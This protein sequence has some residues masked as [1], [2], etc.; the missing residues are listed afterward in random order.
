MKYQNP[1]IESSYREHDIGK[2]LYDLVLKLEPKKIVEIG[3]LHGYSTVAMAMALDEI[4][5]GHLHVYDL[6]EDYQY[7]HGTMD[8]VQ[9]N[10][11]KYGVSEYVTLTKK[12]FNEWIQ[13]PEDFDLLHVDISNNGDVIELLYEAVKDQVEQGKTVVFEGGSQERDKVP[14]MDKYGKRRIST[15][16][17]P[18]EVIDER[19]P[20]L[21]MIRQIS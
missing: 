3:C 19:F 6:F 14:W 18:F 11:E 12:D 9:G 13:R 20:S 2:T 10:V 5:S 16:E 17:V 4:G 15:A 21:S 8:E 1:D 7:K